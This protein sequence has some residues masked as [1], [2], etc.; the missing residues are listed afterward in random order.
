MSRLRIELNEDHLKL[1][2]SFLMG[3]V[4]IITRPEDYELRTKHLITADEITEENKKAT[5]KELQ[6]YFSS[7]EEKKRLI[8]KFGGTDGNALPYELCKDRTYDDDTSGA[9]LYGVNLRHPYGEG[10]LYEKIALIL[11]KY[12][13]CI[14]GT[15]SDFDG[16]KFS[17]EV[18]EYMEGVHNYVMENIKYI[19]EIVHQYIT[20]GGVTP[21]VYTAKHYARIWQKEA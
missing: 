16:P 7:E 21:G 3:D 17:K 4:P 1:V 13:Q 14:T 6:N 8:E 19:E 12:D 10:F 9:V 18:L 5:S 2:S 11:G 15:E 20:K